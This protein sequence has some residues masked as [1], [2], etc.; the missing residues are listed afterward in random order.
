M[1]ANFNGSS[2]P[3][4]S[5]LPELDARYLRTAAPDACQAAADKIHDRLVRLGISFEG[6]WLPLSLRPSRLAS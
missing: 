2:L 1:N 6:R 4:T 3:A 5:W